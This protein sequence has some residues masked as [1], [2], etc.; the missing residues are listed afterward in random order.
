MNFKVYNL[1]VNSGDSYKSSPKGTL[2][3]GPAFNIPAVQAL[4][5]C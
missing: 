1:T 2:D 4:K 5:G 3:I